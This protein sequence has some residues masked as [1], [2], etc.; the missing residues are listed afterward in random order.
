MNLEEIRFGALVR[1]QYSPRS[2]PIEG[3]FVGWDHLHDK[4]WIVRGM[5]EEDYLRRRGPQHMLVQQSEIASFQNVERY[6]PQRP[7]AASPNDDQLD[8]G[9]DGN[10]AFR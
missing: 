8:G 7:L 5:P 1:I 3:L 9:E 2:E 4:L 6:E 10:T